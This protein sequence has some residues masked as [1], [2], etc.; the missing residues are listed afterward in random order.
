MKTI[1]RADVL[2]DRQKTELFSLLA[3]C[4]PDPARPPAFPVEEASPFFFLYSEDGPQPAAVL[5][6][7]SE[8]A[9]SPDPDE[10]V[11]CFAF[12]RPAQRQKG[13]F[14]A[15]LQECLPLVGERELLFPFSHEDE[16]G[17]LALEAAG[18]EI[19]CTEYRM[20]RAL[21]AAL[22]RLL[23]APRLFLCWEE[24]AKAGVLTLSCR[25]VLRSD[26]RREAAVCRIDVPD[27]RG[28]GADLP[29]APSCGADLSDVCG[30][31]ADLSGARGGGAD[32]P[33]A[34]GCK[35]DLSGARGCFY[36]F[37]VAPALRGQKIGEETLL[38]AL[39]ALRGRGLSSL[40]LHVSGD[41]TAAL[42]LY[43]KTGFRITETLS[44]YLY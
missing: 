33:G 26:P 20:E 44:Y 27:T 36:G 8:D 22:P 28:G 31:G 10:P 40:F 1:V 25:A 34:R 15:L 5:A 30:G 23:R 24:T 3:A 2:N 4:A 21:D 11:E 6:L 41:N 42:G 18:A 12:T 38:L 16:A 43:Q 13:F 39:E 35:A 29:G 7:L 17:R 32:F 37:Q 19:A 14:S 9:G